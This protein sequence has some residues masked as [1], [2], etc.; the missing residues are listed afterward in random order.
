MAIPIHF[1]SRLSPSVLAL[2]VVTS[3]EASSVSLVSDT[4]NSGVSQLTGAGTLNVG[5]TDTYTLSSA[6]LEVSGSL[7]SAGTATLV[8]SSAS[9]GTTDLVQSVTLNTGIFK[10]DS[11]SLLLSGSS[12][13]AGP[14]TTTLAGSLL[15]GSGS[16]PG[17]TT[18]TNGTG[19]M[20]PGGG[21]TLTL[22]VTSG[23]PYTFTTAGGSL[24]SGSLTQL[25]NVASVFVGS[26]TLTPVKSGSS[27]LT[28]TPA[29]SAT[30]WTVVPET[31]AALLGGVGLLAL[32]R[33]RRD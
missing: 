22:G 16:V 19:V 30:N 18:V 4:Q 27:T 23:V 26:G 7:V 11:D 12:T 20:A 29:T 33:R 10:I 8:L 21:D 2:A 32:L 6:S 28:L 9:A 3:A 5:A 25:S 17:M 13:Y 24:G 15:G 1:L 31:S 14:T